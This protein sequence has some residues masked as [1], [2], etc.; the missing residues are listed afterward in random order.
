MDFEM[1]SGRGSHYG[2]NGPKWPKN[3]PKWKLLFFTLLMFKKTLMSVLAHFVSLLVQNW[4]PG[5][6]FII[7]SAKSDFFHFWSKITEKWSKQGQNEAFCA[8]MIILK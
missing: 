3:G 6:N 8:E 7:Q 5:D 2:H 4:T 1:R